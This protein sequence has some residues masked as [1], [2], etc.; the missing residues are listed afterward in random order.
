MIAHE[1]SFLNL[2]DP[3]HPIDECM[4]VSRQSVGI[5][6][7][8]EYPPRRTRKPARPHAPGAESGATEW[9]LRGITRLSRVYRLVFRAVQKIAPVQLARP[10]LARMFLSSSPSP[11]SKS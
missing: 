8:S 1:F 5:C 3:L 2:D 11:S 10:K 6:A 7:L 9:R 4:D